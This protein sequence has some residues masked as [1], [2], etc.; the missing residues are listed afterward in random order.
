M[1]DP[2]PAN[3]LVRSPALRGRVGI[4]RTRCLH[5]DHCGP[6]Q[7]AVPSMS[8]TPQMQQLCTRR[9]V[10]AVATCL[11]GRDLSLLHMHGSATSSQCTCK[12][13]N[14][15]GN[16]CSRPMQ[17]W[18]GCRLPAL[19]SESSDQTTRKQ[20]LRSAVQEESALSCTFYLIAD[21]ESTQGQPSKQSR[22]GDAILSPRCSMGPPG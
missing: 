21:L 6:S 11:T 9:L 20:I 18:P 3:R 5:A 12:C 19:P 4:R 1:A 16:A 15:S 8:C 2:L 17:E 22:L 7:S 14:M 13:C 10:L